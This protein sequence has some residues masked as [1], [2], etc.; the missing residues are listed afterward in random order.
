MT[1]PSHSHDGNTRVSMPQP[2][3]REV[4][5]LCVGLRKGKREILHIGD[6]EVLFWLS[7]PV[8]VKTAGQVYF[9]NPGGSA[10]T[11]A[12]SQFAG[13]EGEAQHTY[14]LARV[15]ARQFDFILGQVLSKAA[16]PLMYHRKEEP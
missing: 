12:I 5:I 15:D 4:K 14:A 3:A 1:N 16:V 11:R 7:D 9:N 13:H 10:I 2:L 8:A 6:S